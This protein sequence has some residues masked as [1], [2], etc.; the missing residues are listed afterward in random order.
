MKVRRKILAAVALAIALADGGYI[1]R[2]SFES[3]EDLKA[4]WVAYMPVLEEEQRRYPT[5]E[6]TSMHSR[7]SAYPELYD[8]DNNGVYPLFS[9]FAGDCKI[10]EYTITI[11]PRLGTKNGP[12]DMPIRFYT[13]KL[14]PAKA[15]CLR[16]SLPKGY[17]LARLEHE[18]DPSQIGWD[19]HDLH[20]AKAP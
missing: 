20:L 17:V 16:R 9:K 3:D 12:F 13:G 11:Y 15:A 2:L 1:I 14:N 4:E 8:I 5:M 18:V 6:L 10:Q 19:K 7:N